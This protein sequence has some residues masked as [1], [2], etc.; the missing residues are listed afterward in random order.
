M[1][2]VQIIKASA[3]S[4]KTFRLTL[5]YVTRVLSENTPRPEKYRHILA[6]TF[7]NK[8]TEEMKRRIIE[9]LAKLAEC[10]E[11]EFSKKV[12][13]N[14]NI[15]IREAARRAKI[16]LTKILHDYTHF[17]VLTIDKFFQ[18]IIRSFTHELG[19]DINYTLELQSK[20]VIE[21]AVDI[22]FDETEKNAD[23]KNWLSEYIEERIADNKGWNPRSE[24]IKLGEQ[25]FKQNGFESNTAK[26]TKGIIKASI[27]ELESQVT[28]QKSKLQG[29]A[30]ELLE[31]IRSKGITPPT[32]FYR[33]ATGFM[34]FF[35]KMS[36]G[37]C[38]A[39]SPAVVTTVTSGENWT[40]KDSPHKSVVESMT[41]QWQTQMLNILDENKLLIKL[42][43]TLKVV[44]QNYRTFA[45]LPDIRDMLD[46]YCQENAVLPIADTNKIVEGLVNNNDAPFI[47][48]KTG[49]TFT[50]YMLDEFQDTSA[51]QWRNF[52]PLISN[53][54]SQSDQCNV[55]LVGDVK[56]SIY[57][58]R[59]GDWSLLANQVEQQFD[60]ISEPLKENFR[61]EDIVIKFNNELIGSNLKDSNGVNSTLNTMLSEACQQG[62]IPQPLCAEL[63][64]ITNN[65]YAG[66]EQQLP[67]HKAKG[68][69]Y[70]SVYCR[71]AE[72]EENGIAHTIECIEDAQRR[73]IRASQIAILVRKNDEANEVATALLEYKSQHPESPYVYDI[74]TQEALLL[75]HSAAVKFVIAALSYMN[76]S[77]DL[78]SREIFYEFSKFSEEQCEKLF[79]QLRRMTPIKAIDTIIGAV[80]ELTQPQH[81]PYI[82]ALHD[83]VIGFSARNTPDTAEFLKW[84]ADNCDKLSITISGEQNAINILTI[85]KAKGLQYKAVIIPFCDWPMMP[86][87]NS[88]V[89]CQAD[90]T[91]A[92]NLGN[93][94]VSFT[95][96][97]SQ[98]YYSED[99]YREVVSSYID[100]LNL[101]YVAI[102]RAEFE[103]YVILPTDS[104]KKKISSYV[105]QAFR[106][107]DQGV[108]I[109][110]LEGRINV[111][112]NNC[113]IYEFGDK[114]SAQSD[115]DSE[116]DEKKIAKLNIDNY[117]TTD[118]EKKVNISLT[119]EYLLDENGVGHTPRYYGKLM[120][121]LLE[122]TGHYSEL[123]KTIE[124]FVNQNKISDRD[125]VVIKEML[126]Q[127]LSDPTAREWFSD[128][129][130][131]IKSEVNII[132]PR[133]KIL[134]RPDRVMI[135]DN[136]AIV[137][138]YKFGSQLLLKKYSQK[139]SDYMDSLREMGYT[140][141]RGYLW[142]V[143]LGKI[144]EVM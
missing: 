7:T 51:E 140:D 3:G 38:S 110:S 102:T 101:L 74:V 5:E 9:E 136:R 107:D 41:G 119:S 17:T 83:N 131:T 73:G 15:P 144:F 106:L 42:E 95:S 6:V 141:V 122:K 21:R 127:A 40:K 134:Q 11:S 10:R 56:Q 120:H 25:L 117:P 46:R 100:N 77:D 76:N 112:D 54:V 143:A 64:D 2:K 34:N 80:A 116:S 88:I 36:Q 24:F 111:K 93:V 123:D 45:V 47:Y 97:L 86:K 8:A 43:Q 33:G 55:L 61:S 118:S 71:D 90:D 67:S 48:E 135:R 26:L 78:V 82:Q 108:A 14:L 4:G 84:W 58:W 114:Y 104:D 85:H 109:G 19:Q 29:L 35:C 79:T 22:L 126:T 132:N 59:G 57:R 63:T 142:F 113:V 70:V 138:D 30:S 137:I 32:D 23:F 16:V 115:S 98:S 87:A 94:P 20:Q 12:C 27:K 28:A 105:T 50:D 81:I 89:W 52:K 1:G 128:Q 44:R 133:S 53:A 37:I 96:A 49:N 124:D 139:I 68:K 130:S 121:S 75:R 99:Y 72:L 66:F 60:T 92:R 13:A 91:S 39:P 69:G 31:D 65:A 18:R 103:L 125:A 62:A 129:W